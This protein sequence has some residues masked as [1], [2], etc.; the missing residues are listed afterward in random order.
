MKLSIIIPAHNEENRIARTL[1]DYGKKY[2]KNAEI[3]VVLNGCKDNTIGIVKKLKKKYAQIRYLNFQQSGKGFAIIEGFK[4][5][6]GDFIGFADADDA[7]TALEFNRLIEEIDGFDGAIGSRWM[8]D[9]IIIPKQPLARIIAGRAFNLLNRMMFGLKFKDTQCGAKLFTKKVVNKII[10][11]LGITE[12]AFDADL[13]YEM[14]REGFK[15]KE[16]A[17]KWQ[18][19]GGSKLN[20]L[21]TPLRMFLSL[22]RL[23]LIYSPFKFI[24]KLYDKA[25][26]E[27]MKIHHGLK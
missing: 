5:A 10:P 2:G 26:P 22:L 23:R 14:K 4:A 1:E 19:V 8:K 18:D 9:S 20:I 24:I 12:W 25:V 21:K 7:T 16:V 13:L 6:K 3:I 15:V 11:K 17:I 27:W